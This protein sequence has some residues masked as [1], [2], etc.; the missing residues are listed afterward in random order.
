MDVVSRLKAAQR[1]MIWAVLL[2]I[3]FI[4]INSSLGK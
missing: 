2:V 4:Y 3:R 1:S